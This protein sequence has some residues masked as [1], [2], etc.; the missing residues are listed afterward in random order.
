MQKILSVMKVSLITVLATL[1]MTISPAGVYAEGTEPCV[2]PE[3]TSAGN[4]RPAGADAAAYTYNCATGL[5]ESERYV[6]YPS[7]GAV[8]AK[9][10]PVYTYNASTGQWDY[11]TWVYNAPSAGYIAWVRSVATP[12]AGAQTVGGPPAPTPNPTSPTGT[13]SSSSAAASTGSKDKNSSKATTDVSPGGATA[14]AQANAAGVSANSQSGQTTNNTTNASM[15]NTVEADASSGDA[16]VWQN[17]LAG[18]ALSGNAEAMATLI[19]LLQSASNSFGNTQGLVTF[20]SNIY[21][22]VVGDLM[23]DPAQLVSLLGS[24]MANPLNNVTY[25]SN[26]N[27]QITNDVDLN[28]TSGNADVVENT[29]AG[30][31]TSGNARA[32]A[33]IINIINSAISSGQSFLGVVNINGNLDGDILLPPDFIDQLIAANVPTTTIDTGTLLGDSNSSATINNNNGI[34]NN[35]SASAS[36]GNANVD[37]NTSAGNATTGLARTNITAF[38]LT[39]SQTIGKNSILVFVNVMGE[40]IGMIVNAPQGATAAQL[41]GGVSQ[42]SSLA[43]QNSE[44]NATTNNQITNNINVNA[45]SGDAN[46]S[47][48]T[49]AG[50]ATSGSADAAVNLL[51]IANSAMSFSDWFGVLFINVFGKWN[52]SFGVDTAAGNKPAPTAPVVEARPVLTFSFAPAQ[53]TAS[54]TGRVASSDSPTQTSTEATEEAQETSTLGSATSTPQS[55]S[56]PQSQVDKLLSRW[57]V[58]LLVSGGLGLLMLAGERLVQFVRS[59]QTVTKLSL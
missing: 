5:W 56:T 9:D 40:W 45:E 18:S 25:N 27:N 20:I 31:A 21:G 43:S 4:H 13:G 19:S 49:T 1:L 55:G 35:V 58:P 26:A 39:G 6:Y 41:G 46:V 10:T 32:V 23:L 38:N 8:V 54:P 15:N 12:P 2:P 36:S 11:T 24:G 42:N 14:S 16:G 37:R 29:T 51:N 28:A 52:G 53:A 48:N 59:R 7:T 17:T 22:D 33:N 34:T 47:R 3:D 57:T 30:D 44:L 50:N